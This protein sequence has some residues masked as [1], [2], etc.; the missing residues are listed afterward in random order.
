[1]FTARYVLN[2]YIKQIRFVFKGRMF[3]VLSQAFFSAVQNELPVDK[4]KVHY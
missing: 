2:A 4:G 1:V 3:C